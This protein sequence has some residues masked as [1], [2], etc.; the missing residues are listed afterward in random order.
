MD[1]LKRGRRGLFVVLA[2]MFVVCVAVAGCSSDDDGS[3]DTAAAEAS[4]TT[5]GDGGG[6]GA[7]TG[8]PKGKEVAI[9]NITRACEGC[10]R[11]ETAFKEAAE[12]LGMKVRVVDGQGDPNRISDQFDTLVESGVDGIVLLAIDP[13][14]VALDKAKAKDIPVVAEFLGGGFDPSAFAKGLNSVS[15]FNAVVESAQI[16]Q[17]F[18]AELDKR[19]REAGK[20]GKAKI[21]VFT[22]TPAIPIHRLR[23]AAFN[24][25]LAENKNKV[26]VVN[27]HS[28]DLA[29]GTTDVR[30]T[31]DSVL[32][33]NPDLDAVW[34]M[35]DLEAMPTV[36]ALRARD[37]QDKVFLTT[38]VAD[39][40]IVKDIREGGPIVA[41]VDNPSAGIGYMSADTMAK[42]FSGKKYAELPGLTEVPMLPNVITKNNVPAEG[43]DP[44]PTDVRDTFKQQWQ[45]EYGVGG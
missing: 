32:T 5:S 31:M 23:L 34:T 41:T 16:S 30:N 38:F 4:A 20:T 28:T 44:E 42:I 25:F 29:N 26:E 7:T 24:A 36:E 37:M 40:A 14:S 15:D 45:K 10:L 11:N 17:L 3:T 43:K 9:I 21:A 8:G 19:R 6:G 18:F 27:K 1:Q 22:G 13:N 39:K 2:L 33:A 12:S 35:Q